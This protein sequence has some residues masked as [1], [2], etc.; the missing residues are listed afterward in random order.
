[1]RKIGFLFFAWVI[2]LAGQAAFAKTTFNLSTPDPDDAEITVAA[3]K[4]A[5]LVATKIVLVLPANNRTLISV[6]RLHNEA[7]MS[8]PRQH[9]SFVCN[10]PR[11]RQSRHA[12]ASS[13]TA[14]TC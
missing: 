13:Q 4:F 8:T 6:P 11:C 12:A 14:T 1:M 3:K 9:A 7:Y 10:V 2:A 5:E